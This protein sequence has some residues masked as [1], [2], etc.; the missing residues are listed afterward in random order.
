MNGCA[1]K[2]DG[3]FWIENA[4]SGLERFKGFI[5]VRKDTKY[6]GFDTKANA[7]RNVFLCWLEPGVALGLDGRTDGRRAGGQAER[8]K[9]RLRQR[10]NKWG[11]R[12]EEGGGSKNE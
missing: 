7:C 1:T 8:S 12:V 3:D 2:L 9:I 11:Q 6:A 10:S 4:Y 5:L